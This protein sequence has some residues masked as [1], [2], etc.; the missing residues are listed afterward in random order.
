MAGSRVGRI[1]GWVL[2]VLVAAMMAGPSAA[3]KLVEW[4]GKAEM[5]AKL[6]WTIDSMYR[7][8]FVEIA[9]AVLFLIPR[10]SLVGAILLTAYLGGAVATHVRIGDA[11]IMPVILGVVVWVA[12]G[13]RR[14]SFWAH[15]WG[16]S[17][18]TAA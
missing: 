3:G 4:E 9:C 6:G 18:T 2:S 16:P 15:V 7:I 10:T 1:V 8:A 13:L 11:W 17:D 12:Y 14:P 5:F